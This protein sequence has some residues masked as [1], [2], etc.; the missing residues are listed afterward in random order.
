MTMSSLGDHLLDLD[1]SDIT[2]K[3]Q[4]NFSESSTIYEVQIYGETRVMKLFHDN[5]DPGYSKRGRD[6]NRFR[7]ELNAYCNLHKFGV[8]ERGFVPFFYG[9]IDRVDP[10]AFAPPLTHFIHD[11]F[12]PR[13]ILLEY[14]PNAERLNCVNYSEALFQ[15]AVDGIKEIH[16]AL[17]HHHDIYPKNMLVVSGS[18]IVWID[19]DVA[20]TF[21]DMGSREKEYCKYEAD[22]V[23]NFGEVLRNDQREGLPPNTKFY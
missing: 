14:L 2:I 1:P 3:R 19:F 21:D 17:V 23:E 9:Y 20:M 13:A 11:Q 5:G 15:Y 6:L 22:L 12:Q 7:C 16:S 8:C 10:S 4:I 18:R